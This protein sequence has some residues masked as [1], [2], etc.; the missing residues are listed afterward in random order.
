ME[1]GLQ[2]IKKIK[3][4]SKKVIQIFNDLWIISMP[5]Y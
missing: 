5:F 2:H 1:F 3:S 4:L